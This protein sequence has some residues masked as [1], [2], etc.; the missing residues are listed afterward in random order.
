LLKSC[1]TPPANVALSVRADPRAGA[2]QADATQLHQVLL[3]LAANARDAMAA[4]GGVLAITVDRAAAPGAGAPAGLA[5]GDYVRLAV[6]DTGDGMDAATQA[7]V[8]EPYFTTKPVGAGSGLGLSV[9]HGIVAALGGAV[10]VESAAGE[11]TRVEVW[12]PRLGAPAPTVPEPTARAAPPSG[13][14]VLLVDDDP[15]VARALGRMVSSLGC[16]VTVEGSAEAALERFR[17]APAGFD[18]VITDQTLP[19][20]GGDELTRAL[21]AIRPDLPVLICTGYSARLDDAEA[22]AIGARALLPKPIDRKELGDA[23]AAA[24]AVR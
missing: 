8:F 9:V 13:R 18:V 3:N 15:P 2:V 7:R 11:G 17:E 23:L 22:R 14:R 16:Q 5:R 4:R 6:A 19:R 12:L 20:M 24:L 10:T 21:L 1:A